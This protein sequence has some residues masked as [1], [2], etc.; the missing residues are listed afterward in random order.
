MGCVHPAWVLFIVVKWR[1]VYGVHRVQVHLPGRRVTAGATN[2]APNSERQTPSSCRR[3]GPISKRINRL[4][5]WVMNTDGIGT[6]NDCAGEAQ[7]QFTRPIYLTTPPQTTQSEGWG[8]KIWSWVRWS[9]EARPTV[10]ARPSSNL[11]DRVQIGL[12][13]VEWQ[14]NQCGALCNRAVSVTG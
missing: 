4:V 8:R 9:P 6:K 3:G 7:Q 13:S 5:N 10:L 14:N 1:R 2:V 12:K 11:P